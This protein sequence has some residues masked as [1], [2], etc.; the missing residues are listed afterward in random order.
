MWINFSSI[1]LSCGGWSLCYG[2]WRRRG[3]GEKIYINVPCARACM[4]GELIVFNFNDAVKNDHQQINKMSNF[5]DLCPHSILLRCGL[6]AHSFIRYSPHLFT[7]FS[8]WCIFFWL[9]QKMIFFEWV[10]L[11][12]RWKRTFIIK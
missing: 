3:G 1:S 10:F 12:I 9:I 8:F 2:L 4:E 11:K 6:V 7:H 5:W